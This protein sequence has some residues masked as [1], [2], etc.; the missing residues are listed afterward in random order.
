MIDIIPTLARSRLIVI[1]VLW[2]LRPLYHF[3]D[4]LAVE[5]QADAGL[6]RSFQEVVLILPVEFGDLLHHMLN[7]A[8]HLDNP[9]R[10]AMNV[11]W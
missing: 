7:I 11:K 2:P 10:S 6:G 1:Q 4:V 9:L 5:G 8:L 3:E